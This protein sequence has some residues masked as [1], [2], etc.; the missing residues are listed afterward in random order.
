[1][2]ERAQGSQA[3]YTPASP[4]HVWKPNTT[5]PSGGQSAQ[6]PF[7]PGLHLASLSLGTQASSA[8]LGSVPHAAH[9]VTAATPSATIKAAFAGVFGRPSSHQGVGG[10][11]VL[12]R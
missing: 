2:R 3:A 7:S 4:L 11:A 5:P 10:D 9:A 8:E 1:M 12:G 6:S